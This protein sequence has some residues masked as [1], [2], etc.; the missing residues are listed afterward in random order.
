[1]VTV[2]MIVNVLKLQMSLI[3]MEPSNNLV[4]LVTM[5]ETT[6]LMESTVESVPN[7]TLIV[8]L[9]TVLFT[10]TVLNVSHLDTYLLT[11][12]VSLTV[13]MVPMKIVPLVNVLHVI[14]LVILVSDKVLTNVMDVLNQDTSN[15]T[16]VLTHVPLLL[17]MVMI[18]PEPVDL[19][20]T[21]VENVPVQ[22]TTNVSGV[23]PVGI[24]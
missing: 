12:F 5:L 21:L 24:Y 14:T 8:L 20:T 17:T 18:P 11:E 23:I 3:L 13:Q 1:M 9:V 16:T 6:I 19:V 10:P 15:K 4:L 2:F 22:V 7:V